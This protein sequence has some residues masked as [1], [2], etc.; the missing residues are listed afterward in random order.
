MCRY[1][2]LAPTAGI[3]G[4]RTDDGRPTGILALGPIHKFGDHTVVLGARR[5]EQSQDE[6]HAVLVDGEP[7]SGWIQGKPSPDDMRAVAVD[8]GRVTFK[9]RTI[10]TL[11]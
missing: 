2:S 10:T 3:S 1:E 9:G 11:I 8:E 5:G 4:V 6:E 7:V